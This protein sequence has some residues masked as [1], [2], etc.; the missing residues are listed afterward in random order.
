MEEQSK[1]LDD[2]RADLNARFADQTATFNGRFDDLHAR[3]NDVQARVGGVEGRL[4]AL[5]AKVEAGFAELRTALDAKPSAR[6]LNIWMM[7]AIAWMT[8][9]ATSVSALLVWLVGRLP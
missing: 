6:A 9:L 5:E 8:V 7:M 4:I 1:R 2:L 3:V